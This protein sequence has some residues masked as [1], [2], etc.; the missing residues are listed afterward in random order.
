MDE[1]L[2]F[3][4]NALVQ[5]PAI[6][7]GFYAFNDSAINDYIFEEFLKD[8]L[9]QEMALDVSQLP[10]YI[11]EIASGSIVEKNVS[12]EHSSWDDLPIDTQEKLLERLGELGLSIEEL[13]EKGYEV[14]SE[15]EFEKRQEFAVSKRD[16]DPEGYTNERS[17]NYKIL[18]Q[19]QGPNDDKTRSFCQRLLQLKLIFRKEDIDK[20]SIKGANSQE[21]GYYD[22]FTYRGSYG[23]RHR[24]KKVYVYQ[25][26][27]LD[28]L[29]A[30]A[31][32]QATGGDRN[33]GKF[34]KYSFAT[35][36]KE[37]RLIGPLMIPNKAILRVD[38]EGEP[39]YVYFSA[40]TIA[41]IARKMMKEKLLDK[42][43]LEHD[44]N[45]PV[46]GY[47][48]EAW[49][50][51]DPE[52]DKSNVYGFSFPEGTWMGQYKL[53][54]SETE[55]WNMIEEGKITGFSIEGAFESKAIQ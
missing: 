11:N 47:M 42:L 48:E 4:S 14:L 54:E 20:L 17:G 2:G 32:L 9:I 28:P 37:R 41:T 25:S 21:F 33:E 29:I 7:H 3:E 51:T 12:Q 52:K 5:S 8:Y 45:R 36:K 38:E 44:S 43:N 53:D 16:A 30:A 26:K 13:I 39:Y 22:I 49:I 19:Y 1:L 31:M 18:F 50:I 35:D 6:E 23:C 55:I 27:G 34:N 15:E 40:S 10:A 46:N 24:W